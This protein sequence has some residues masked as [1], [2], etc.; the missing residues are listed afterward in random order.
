MSKSK[1][2]GFV[3]EFKT[4][5]NQGSVMDLAV[6]MVMGTAFS[7]IVNSLVNDIV[8]PAVGLLLGGV[9]FTDLK[10]VIPNFFG[11]NTAAIIRY[12]SFIQ[13]VVNFLVIALSIFL[14]IKFLNKMNAKAK[15]T[16]EKA[17]KI[18]KSKKP[19]A[20]KTTKK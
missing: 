14:V 2:S 3:H 7:A 17:A 10:V 16:A 6:G 8:M 13:Q 11:G 20:K 1:E 9:N 15:E 5:I 12:G 18:A 19:A 4:F